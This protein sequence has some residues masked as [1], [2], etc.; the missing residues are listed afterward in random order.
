M[1]HDCWI[2][3][4]PATLVWFSIFCFTSLV[5][6]SIVFSS[7]VVPFCQNGTVAIFLRRVYFRTY[8]TAVSAKW[9]KWT[10]DLAAMEA[11]GSATRVESMA[12]TTGTV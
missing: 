9:S 12:F 8:N 5:G 1:R 11:T 2:I 7:V 4:A 3:Y 6:S 10:A